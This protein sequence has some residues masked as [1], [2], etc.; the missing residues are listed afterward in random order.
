MMTLPHYDERVFPTNYAFGL[1]CSE[2]SNADSQ[3]YNKSQDSSPWNSEVSVTGEEQR[4]P[5][6]PTAT[7]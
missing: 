7:T 5:T 6:K 3:E 4:S 1:K 2:F